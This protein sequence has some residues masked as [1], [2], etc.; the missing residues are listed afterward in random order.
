MVFWALPNV[1][2]SVIP[3]LLGTELAGA[4]ISATGVTGAALL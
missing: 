2:P 4:D 3:A 1:P